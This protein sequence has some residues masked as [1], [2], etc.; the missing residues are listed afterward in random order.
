M[1]LRELSGESAAAQI[2]LVRHGETAWS[3]AGR[4]TGRT[5][6]PLTER[7]EQNARQVGERLQGVSFVTVLS[8]PLSRARRT[9]ELAGFGQKMEI[10]PDLQEWDYG[11][12]EGCRTPDI[13]KTRP[14]WNIFSDGCPGGE[15]L[16]QI[17]ARADRIVIRLRQ[18]KGDVAVFSHG[19]F[20]RILAARWLNLPATEGRRFLLHAAAVSILGYEHNSADE[21]VL[22]LWNDHRHTGG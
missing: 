3:L 21:P 15:T 5:D 16:E 19:H 1:G 13:R 8:S 9:C 11:E 17:R 20:L 2:H 18:A 6:V 12:Y 4:H 22:V 7:G 10:N 14:G